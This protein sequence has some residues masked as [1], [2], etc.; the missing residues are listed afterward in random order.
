MEFLK[1]ANKS[2]DRIL[3]NKDT[4]WKIGVDVMRDATNI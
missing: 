4:S 3:Q 2:Y 1:N